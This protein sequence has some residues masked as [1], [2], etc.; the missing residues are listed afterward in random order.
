M[1]IRHASIRNFS[2]HWHE[3]RHLH[4]CKTQG[5]SNV[6]L[7]GHPDDALGMA[8]SHA[9]VRQDL[10]LHKQVARVS[11]VVAVSRLSSSSNFKCAA[12]MLDVGRVR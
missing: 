3:F 12:T 5:V 10:R 9:H 2:N 4:S 7:Q 6:S 11:A 8:G 1:Y